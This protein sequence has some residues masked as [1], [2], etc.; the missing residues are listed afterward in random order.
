[1]FPEEET[2][3]QTLSRITVTL[4][5][6]AALGVALTFFIPE[7]DHQK[8]LDRDI[9][10]LELERQAALDKRDF[11]RKELRLLNDDPDYLEIKARD[12]L[13]MYREGENILR[14]EGGEV[15]ESPDRLTTGVRSSD[16]L[17][18]G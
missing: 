17:P 4:I 2:I 18:T 15:V 13:D 10:R 9:N 3:W 11:L 6:V 8:A 14:I 1:M 12:R 7:L 5:I 16:Q